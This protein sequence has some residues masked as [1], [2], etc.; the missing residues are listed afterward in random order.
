MVAAGYPTWPVR[1]SADWLTAHVGDA[2][3]WLV[4]VFVSDLAVYFDPVQA[5]RR[6]A[7]RERVAE[8]IGE[9]R[10]R[11]LI[12]TRS[13]AW[14]PTRHSEPTRTCGWKCS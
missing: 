1:Q 7:A 11:V 4:T 3:R 12:A 10:P 8:A 14:S 9:H 5:K 13:A 6:D 2:A